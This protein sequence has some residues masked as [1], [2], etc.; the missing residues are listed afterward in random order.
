M[1]SA[2]YYPHK[3]LVSLLICVLSVLPP[4]FSASGT[5]AMVVTADSMATEAALEVL[6]SGGNAV[7][8]AIAA[9]WV[10]NVVEPYGSGIGGGG[11]FLYYDAASKKVYTFDGREKAPAGI[12]LQIFL[13]EKGEPMRFWPERISG[14]LSAGVPGTLKLLETVH[15]RFGSKKISFAQLFEPAIRIAEEGFQISP[16]LA[17]MIESERERLALFPE[18]A[19]IFLDSEGRT[20]MPGVVL[21]QPELAQTFRLIAEKGTEIFYEGEIAADIVKAVR[22][23]PFH[24]GFLSLEDLR[25]YKVVE[26]VPVSIDYR[27]YRIYGMGPPSSGGIT[28]MQSL[29]ILEHYDLPSMSRAE[30]LSLLGQ[31]QWLSF[32]DRN[33]FL[34]DPDYAEVPV[35]RLLSKE[36]AEGFTGAIQPENPGA[37]MKSRADLEPETEP[38]HTTHISIVDAAGNAVSFTTTIEH[39]FGSGLMVPGRGFLLNNELTDFDPYVEAANAPAGGKRPRSSMTPTIVFQGAEPRLVAGSPGGSK[40]IGIITN[41]IVNVLDLGMPLKQALA[42]P[43]VINRGGPLEVEKDLMSDTALIEQLKSWGFEI[44]TSGPMGNVQAILIEESRLTGE[45]DSRGDGLAKG[46]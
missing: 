13:D 5:K 4:A 20:K 22:E 31:A 46:F 2:F 42:E 23:A 28:M 16:R 24:P 29:N 19:R 43:R 10:L 6:Q 7:D 45:S 32:R 1:I 9:Q 3:F 8:A 38:E 39:M 41:I 33:D 44:E 14:G 40:I 27:G 18:S 12:T 35:E 21:H 36:Y 37:V 26:R 34:A 25:D 17:G 30:Q 11:F 15:E